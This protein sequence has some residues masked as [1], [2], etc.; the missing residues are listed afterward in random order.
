M[1]KLLKL[2]RGTTSQHSSFAGA[3]GECTVDT[4]KEVLV[5]HDGSTNGGFP[6]AAEDLTNVSSATIAGRLSADS[7]ATSKIAAGALPTDVT[8]ASANIV[9]GTIVNED[10]N[11]SAAIAGTKISPDFGSQNIATTGTISSSG[12]ITITNTN[13]KLALVDSNSNSDFE[14]QNDNGNF[15]IEDT[16]NTANR[17]RIDAT[18]VVN[19]PGN[20]DFGAGID[21]TGAI[22]NTGNITTNGQINIESTSPRL[23]LSDTNSEDDFSVYNQNGNFLVYNEDDNRAD[24]T[25]ASDGQID[26]A[27]NVDC[28]SGLD[29]TGNITVSGTVDGVDVATRD[30]L[31]GG[32]TS[33]SGVLTNGV[34][35]TTQS[36]S[37]NTTKVATTAYVTTAIGNADA[38]PSGTVMLFAQSSAPTGWTKQTT[39]NNKALRVVS[40]S[41]SSG[42]SNAFSNTFAS[43]SLT[44]N[45]GNTTAG[46]NVSVSIANANTSGNV[47]SHTLSINEIPSHSHGLGAASLGPPNGG[48]AAR[49]ASA[50]NIG[51]MSTGNA[52][53]GGGHSHG[54]SGGSHNHNANASF[55][56]SAHNHNISVTNLDLEVQFVDVILAAKD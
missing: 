9:N 2:R 39:H 33:S 6:L 7:I 48:S 23:H 53:G 54:F 40:G 41:A 31:F 11:A 30:T 36:A 46:G 45:A 16:T 49:G 3:E 34:T 56:G 29:V 37:D 51:N 47:N 12:D 10:V 52:G 1:A 55:S 50:A 5:V 24:I 19:I 22:T 21:V 27:G 25:I 13:P 43:R 18:G 38:F 8:V 14:V 28:N 35:A 20:T 15:N 32:L 42:G 4:D 44:A 17:L 26:F